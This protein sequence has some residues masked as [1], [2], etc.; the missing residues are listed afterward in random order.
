MEDNN[1]R[2][3]CAVMQPT[4]LP[5]IG[6]FEMIDA[7]DIFVFLDDVQFQRKS[8]QQRNIIKGPN[9]SVKLTVPVLQKGKRFQRIDQVVINNQENWA[10]RHLKSIEIAY[11]KSPYFKQYLP[12]FKSL[13][14]KKYERLV[15]LNVSFIYMLMEL[16]CIRTPTILSSSLNINSKANMKIIEICRILEVDELYDAAGA[17]NFINDELFQEA[18]VRVVYQ[19]YRHPKYNQL[20]G[21]FISHMSVV[22]LL[23]NEGPR[24]LE[25]IRSGSSRTWKGE[26]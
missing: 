9:G 19:D 17:V 18:N 2:K 11:L 20:H 1:N 13:Y 23:Y 4:Y 21:D 25:V 14:E 3:T 12:A 16:L 15:D 8:W 26:N 10:K 5:W 6:Y 22:D 7:S 24:S